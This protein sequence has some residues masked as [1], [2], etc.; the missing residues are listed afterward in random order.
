M[1][2]LN[3]LCIENIFDGDNEI[4]F[5]TN[6]AINPAPNIEYSTD[7]GVTW[8]AYLFA[9][10]NSVI[11]LALGG[12]CYFRGDNNYISNDLSGNYYLSSSQS[13][14]I[15]G[16]I[17]SLLDK[18]CESTTISSGYCFCG[19]FKLLNVVD[20]SH[21]ILPATI[22]SEYCYCWLFESCASLENAPELPATTLAP[23]C[24]YGMFENCTS[25]K[26][27][28]EL[29]ATT[30]ADSC[31]NNMFNGCASLIFPPKLPATTLAYRCYY[32]MF[33][34]CASLRVLP[35][36]PA[37]TLAP[38]C[39]SLMFANCTSL[40]MSVSYQSDKQ[41]IFK[42]PAIT[43][44]TNTKVFMFKNVP[45]MPSS[46]EINTNYYTNFSPQITNK[47]YKFYDTFVSNPPYE[48]KIIF[49][50]NNQTFNILRRIDEV[51][52]GSRTSNMYYGST[53][54]S[55]NNRPQNTDWINAN[56]VW[57]APGYK[58]IILF[59]GVDTSPTSEFIS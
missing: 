14:N 44:E 51:A 46:P 41:Y 23:Y 17:M 28:P 36:L 19:L 49:K 26:L 56:I 55:S 4:K 5:I 40:K 37:V 16:N 29:P 3:Y 38:Y 10:T 27:P 6:K 22:L 52:S 39:Y 11:T 1:P 45:G 47:K 33:D 31:Y 9:D 54:I 20:A 15:S 8:D 24:Y 42:I 53:K 32:F 48:A 18:T 58:E 50:S 21:L 12:K 2:D 30:L 35:E 57:E 13:I 43:A 25:L 59:G 7:D 34:N